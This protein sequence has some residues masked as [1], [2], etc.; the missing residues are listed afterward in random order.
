MRTPKVSAGMRF[1]VAK[2]VVEEAVCAV[3]ERLHQAGAVGIFAVERPD[4]CTWSYQLF[5]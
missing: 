4:T 2:D 5:Q 1:D 3:L